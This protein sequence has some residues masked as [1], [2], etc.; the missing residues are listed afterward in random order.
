M[1]LKTPVEEAVSVST[2]LN[3]RDT[4]ICDTRIFSSHS[5]PEGH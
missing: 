5:V 3:C 4:N 2:A 1:Y